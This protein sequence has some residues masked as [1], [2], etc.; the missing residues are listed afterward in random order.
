MNN[1]R[2]TGHEVPFTE[3]D[4]FIVSKTD[5]QGTITYTN[6]TF[7]RIADYPPYALI[8]QP[9]NI[10]RHP[11]MPKVAFK[12]LWETL[13]AG[14][15][16]FGFVKNMT[17]TGDHYWVFANVTIDVADGKQVGYYSVRRPIVHRDRLQVVEAL[18]ARLKEIEQS[19]G[20]N[21]AEQF[22][23]AQLKQANMSYRDWVF[24]HYG[25]ED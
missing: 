24:K 2:P 22:L 3:K 7:M 11:D 5:L 17:R 23:H 18:Y 19:Q 6:R 10:I 12:I 1:I 15:E 9:H 21:A 20:I 25:I 4:G 14:K 13:K 16:W 8:G